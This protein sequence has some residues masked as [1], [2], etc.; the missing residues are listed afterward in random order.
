MNLGEQ[1]RHCQLE[2]IVVPFQTHR[3]LV[4][5]NLV[6]PSEAVSTVVLFLKLL[7]LNPRPQASIQETNAL[8]HLLIEI[9]CDFIWMWSLAGDD[10]CCQ[11][12]GVGNFVQPADVDLRLARKR[13]DTIC[14]AL[15]SLLDAL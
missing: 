2:Q 4:R 12:L 1:V 10:L 5:V 14:F 15:L 13:R 6:E 3:N 9:R 8:V 11:R 7:S